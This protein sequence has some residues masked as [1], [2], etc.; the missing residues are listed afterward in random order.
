MAVIDITNEIYI[1]KEVVDRNI[2]FVTLGIPNQTCTQDH[3]RG[4]GVMAYRGLGGEE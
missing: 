3:A 1:R 2:N 4:S